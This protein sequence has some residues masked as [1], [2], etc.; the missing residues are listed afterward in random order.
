MQGW[1]HR[2][3]PIGQRIAYAVGTL[4]ILSGCVHVLVWLA[5]GSSLSGPVSWRKP[6]L[7]GFSAG[8]TVLSIGWVA[9]KIKARRGDSLLVASFSVALLG[10][11]GL[12]SLQ[13]WRGVPSHYN[14]STPFDASVHFWMEWLVVFATV[15]IFDLT[16]RTFRGLQSSR[17]MRLAIQSGMWLLLVS[18]LLGFALVQHGNQ[19]QALGKAPEV[20]GAAGV[21][22]FP[23]G[24]PIHAIQMLPVLAWLFARLGVADRHRLLGVASAVGGL[25]TFTV[26]SLVQTLS[27]RARFD[28]TPVPAVILGLA[29]TLFLVPMVL[30]MARVGHR[31][32]G[33]RAS[34]LRSS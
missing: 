21:A 3:M 30:A 25:V 28:L 32:R 11:V 26:F 13:Q 9:S 20:V 17:D 27:G 10:E 33:F 29:A 7:F 8:V 1:R 34:S 19:Q 14:R 22:K 4:L 6:I 24:V 12:I 16:L 18:C 5:D 15:V 31:L 23:H 2:S